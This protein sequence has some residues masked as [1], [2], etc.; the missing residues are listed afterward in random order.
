MTRMLVTREGELKV[1]NKLMFQ[2][3]YPPKD[4]DKVLSSRTLPA[5]PLVRAKL[6]IRERKDRVP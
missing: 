2:T 4:T 1:T 3:V 5:I 6:S